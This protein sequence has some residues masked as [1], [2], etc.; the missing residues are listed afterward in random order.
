M[1]EEAMNCAK[2][3]STDRIT[4]LEVSSLLRELHKHG[5]RDNLGGI[6]A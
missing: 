2:T 3:E 4:S 5:K 1:G 6:V